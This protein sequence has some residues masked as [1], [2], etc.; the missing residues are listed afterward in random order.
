MNNVRYRVNPRGE[1]RSVEEIKALVINDEGLRLSDIAEVVYDNKKRTYARHLDRKYAIGVSVFK[2][3]GANLVDVG[4]RAVE[5]V[6]RIGNSSEMQGI[7]LFF[8]D[9]QSEGVTESLSELLKAGL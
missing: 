9:N 3:N 1:F 6:N 5:E 8:L 7:N 4:Q 2:E